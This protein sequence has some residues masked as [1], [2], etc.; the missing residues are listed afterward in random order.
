MFYAYLSIENPSDIDVIFTKLSL[1]V[2]HHSKLVGRPRLIG[3]LNI[4]DEYNIPAQTSIFTRKGEQGLET[5]NPYNP[6][7]QVVAKLAFNEDESQGSATSE[8]IGELIQKGFI[9]V[10]LRGKAHV[11]PLEFD[12][13]KSEVFKINFWDPNFVILDVF[14]Y[15]SDQNPAKLPRFVTNTS[16]P[17]YNTD[18]ATVVVRALMH[19]PS[20][21][22]LT[23]NNYTFD[24]YT[25]ADES[26]GARR[27][28][29][30]MSID[31]L[32]NYGYDP[33]YLNFAKRRSIKDTF[34]NG[35]LEIP[36]NKNPNIWSEV[37]FALNFTDPD[38]WKDPSNPNAKTRE[39]MQW[40]F[41]R[42][43]ND[44]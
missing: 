18:Y 12:Y 43:F 17:N 28:A 40:F 3:T 42:L 15:Y 23:L 31:H 21:V 44:Q 10:D 4:T 8:A 33:D 11:G 39:N 2:Y 6:K 13:K 29:Q 32:A 35:S 37:F 5:F 14:N 16:S 22:P 36:L 27:V 20:G 41:T 24:L 9:S 38:Y 34:L 7:Q 19:N 25:R 1:D 30:G 26:I